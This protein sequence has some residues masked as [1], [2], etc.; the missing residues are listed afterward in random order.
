[1]ARLISRVGLNFRRELMDGQGTS[2]KCIGG[3]SHI[4]TTSGFFLLGGI[5]ALGA[6]GGRTGAEEAVC[7]RAMARTSTV[8][9]GEELA[10]WSWSMED[11][12]W[13]RGRGGGGQVV[14]GSSGQ[15]GLS[16]LSKLA[17]L[18]STKTKRNHHIIISSYHHYQ[19]IIMF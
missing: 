7:L 5:Q 10:A 9:S 2:G 19:L 13:W 15:F 12:A 1:V 16:C 6:A 8:L 11:V 18:P 4:S 14:K 17:C 3:H